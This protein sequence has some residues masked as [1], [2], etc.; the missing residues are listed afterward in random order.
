MTTSWLA[1]LSTYN[2]RVTPGVKDLAGNAIAEVTQPV[3]TGVFQRAA[4]WLYNDVRPGGLEFNPDG[5]YT[6]KATGHEIW[7]NN[8]YGF[9]AYSD[10]TGNFDVQ[11]RMI[12][13]D[14]PGPR[15]SGWARAGL[16]A[17]V[18]GSSS[19]ASFIMGVKGTFGDQQVAQQW[20]RGSGTDQSNWGRGADNAAWPN[21][22]ERIVRRGNVLCTYWNAGGSTINGETVWAAGKRMD[23]A[24]WNGST[25]L[26]QT[27]GAVFPATIALGVAGCT[28]NDIGRA[29]VA[30]VFG[31][32]SSQVGMGYEADIRPLHLRKWYNY[33]N[34]SGAVAF[35]NFTNYLTANFGLN[36]EI[37]DCVTNLSQF[38]DFDH[39]NASYNY[40]TERNV[41]EQIAGVFVAPEEAD[42]VFFLSSDDESKLLLSPTDQPQGKVQ[43]AARTGY[44]T[45]RAYPADSISAPIHLLAGERR[46]LEALM[47]NGG[48]DGHLEVAVTNS[49]GRDYRTSPG[50]IPVASSPP[51]A[52]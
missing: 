47:H 52:S 49:T 23:T 12:S 41:G 26:S 19:N 22:R 34:A 7:A 10:I 48:G 6:L 17:R 35:Q 1:A 46:Y 9:Y 3:P 16:M 27:G 25:G 30:A 43:I 33:Q 18:T 4:K 11:M 38:D 20:R 40:V 31:D 24:D 13:S 37:P 42:Y 32:W 14:S 45:Y 29:P 21:Y 51:A 2:V 5:T 39:M 28:H 50:S 36:D 8:D 44:C 15:G